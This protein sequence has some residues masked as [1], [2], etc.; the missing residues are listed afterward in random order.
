M[1]QRSNSSFESEH[2]LLASA[3]RSLGI[4]VA[5][6]HQ[7]AVIDRFGQ[8]DGLK[9]PGRF[10]VN[11]FTQRVRGY[12]DITPI[13]T[14]EPV[15]N[16]HTHDSVLVAISVSLLHSLDPRTVPKAQARLIVT[17]DEDQ[18]RLN[19]RD[20]AQRVLQDIVGRYPA[21]AIAGGGSLTQIERE[22]QSALQEAL[23]PIGIVLVRAQIREMNVPELI[24][25]RYENIAQR[26]A[27][28][29]DLRKRDPAEYAKALNT[30]M[31]EALP[32]MSVRSVNVDPK[33]MLQSTEKADRD[34]APPVI[35]PAVPPAPHRLPSPESAAEA[36]TDAN[37]DVIDGEVSG[38]EPVSRL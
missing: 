18:H 7:L 35:G 12:I 19:V 25:T 17:W 11:W 4:Y 38:D 10:R 21:K 22:F 24:R 14:S 20:T 13:H 23:A 16:I 9:G 2:L 1:Q 33:A 5:G 30:E 34:G 31:V 32:K 3:G 29:E 15:P 26:D 37:P 28:I 36:G 8:Y 27:T 6:D